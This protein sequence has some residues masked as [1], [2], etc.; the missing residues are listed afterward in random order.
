MRTRLTDPKIAALRPRER[1]YTVWDARI[2]G[3]GVRVRPS[4]YRSYVFL[5]D[6]R[7]TSLGPAALKAV[8]EARREC[9]EGV[10]PAE[11]APS[12]GDFVAN[13]WKAACYGHYKPSTQRRVSSSLNNQLLPTL[14]SA[15]LDWI[16]S[17]EVG[18]WFDWYS[19][20]APDGANRT[21]DVFRQITN[22][23]IACGYVERNP[24]RG[25]KRNKRPRITRF[26]SREELRRLHAELD[27]CGRG[28]ASRRQR[29]D[30]VRLLL[31]TDCRKGGIVKLQWP[32]WTK[33]RSISRAA[34]R[35][36]ERSS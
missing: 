35:V 25:I 2:S 27:G 30:V 6:G 28:T 12:F 21:L 17:T 9:L 16:T 14:G 24:A 5:R 3:L 8:D 36:R 26:L 29:A 7:K 1:E 34:R 10:A 4:G 18:R 11:T 19:R 22:H 33:P 15:P 23:A 31:T 32:K 20:T 13:Q